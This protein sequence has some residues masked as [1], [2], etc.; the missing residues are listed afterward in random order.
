MHFTK[1]E[2]KKIQGKENGVE[3][4]RGRGIG[5]RKEKEMKEKG[6]NRGKGRKTE[7]KEEELRGN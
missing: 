2:R 6:G 5:L 1:I 3:K 4:K 7:G